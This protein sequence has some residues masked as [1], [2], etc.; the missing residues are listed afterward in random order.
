MSAA[1]RDRTV[2]DNQFKNMKA[3]ARH[4]SKGMWYEWRM[5]LLDGL[6]E[7]LVHESQG[8]DQD[9]RLLQEQE[10]AIRT[11]LPSLLE[12]H[13]ALEQ[14]CSTL[15]TRANELANCDQEEL[16]QARQQILSVD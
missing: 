12:E 9:E 16:R 6:K 1:P 7:G 5:K 10:A 2:M 13:T 4:L 3:H 8:L 11:V 14:E 15:Q